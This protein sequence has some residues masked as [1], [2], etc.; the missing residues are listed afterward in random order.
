M[1]H[2]NERRNANIELAVKIGIIIDTELGALSAWMFMTGKGV[3]ESTILRV[4]AHKEQR[5]STD[6]LLLDTIDNISYLCAAVGVRRR[7]AHSETD[8]GRWRLTS[9]I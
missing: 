9:E 3:S 8:G 7:F 4:L 1:A 6:E 5:R 2:E